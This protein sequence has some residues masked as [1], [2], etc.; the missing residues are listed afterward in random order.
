REPML[1]K[2]QI[3]DYLGVEE[4]HGVA[5]RGIAKAGVKLLGHCGAAQHGAA[6]EHADGKARG[7]EIGGA[8]EAV[9]P[10]ADDD[11]VEACG[12]AA[13]GSA[14]LGG[15]REPQS[16]VVESRGDDGKSAVDVGDLAGDAAREVRKEKG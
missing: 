12:A 3:A 7:R 8:G 10:A 11:G 14:T 4:A 9:M 15:H 5:R 16:V 1:G 2:P 6:L 13:S